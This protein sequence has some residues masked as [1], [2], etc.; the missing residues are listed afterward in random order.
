MSL[1]GKVE[2]DV[3]IKA[4]AE[5]FHEIVS[6][7]PHHISNVSPGVIQGCALHEGD[8]GNENSVIN[9]DYVHDGKAKVAKEI[10]EAIDKENNSVTFKVIEGDL[11]EEYKNIKITIQ[12]TPKG[13]GSLVHWTIEYEKLHENIVEPNTLLQLALD[14]S[15]DLD[16]HLVQA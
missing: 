3:E 12:A 8:W 1:F 4:P 5:K 10:I 13:E 14:L 6:C 11:M 16:A 9:W 2:A 15:K 7:R